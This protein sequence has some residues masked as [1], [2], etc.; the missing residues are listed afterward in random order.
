[1][2]WGEQWFCTGP[3]APAGKRFRKTWVA[4]LPLAAAPPLQLLEHP[5]SLSPSSGG[6]QGHSGHLGTQ[7]GQ[8]SCSGTP[9]DTGAEAQDGTG[10]G[11]V[12]LSCHSSSRSL[13]DMEQA[14]V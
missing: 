14:Q 4:I 8:N 13:Q 5:A 12:S 10:T 2:F 3:A 11:Q 1:M 9:R 7:L 6:S